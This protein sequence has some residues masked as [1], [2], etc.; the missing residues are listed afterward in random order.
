ML[1]NNWYAVAD[2]AALTDTPLQFDALGLRFVLFRD[3]DNRIHCL[4]NVCAHRGG[5]LARGRVMDD[6]RIACSYHGWCYDGGGQCVRVPSLDDPGRIPK[7]ARVPSY[8][9]KEK[10]GLVW[11]FL[12]DTPE[13]TRPDIPDL[14]PEFGRP[15]DWHLSLVV[16]DW[17]TDWQ[18]IYE[19]FLDIAHVWHAHS[20]ADF[21]G[22]GVEISVEDDTTWS[23]RYALQFNQP[24][25]VDGSGSDVIMEHSIIGVIARNLQTTPGFGQQLIWYAVCPVSPELTRVFSYFGHDTSQ[26]AEMHAQA[27][28]MIRN[29]GTGEDQH[30]PEDIQPSVTPAHAQGEIWVEA[31]QPELTCRRKVIAAAEALGSIDM[32]K[33]ESLRR[34]EVRV[35]PAPGYS[36]TPR[37]CPY[38]AV[39]LS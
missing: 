25:G 23:T 38:A 9:V 24:A 32:E 11:A 15:D 27:V 31:D 26:S 17:S 13:E 18:R 16:Q 29:Q 10:F 14:L 12:G 30:V 22:E 2:A 20:F 8:P 35:I 6:G 39:P 4:G 3:A 1:I 37:D 34:H 36:G 19:N 7:R 21:L 33:L 28:E 5:S